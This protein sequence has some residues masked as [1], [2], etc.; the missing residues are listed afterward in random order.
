[1]KWYL[2]SLL[3][4]LGVTVTVNAS[5]EDGKNPS[6]FTVTVAPAPHLVED[7]VGTWDYIDKD[8]NVVDGADAAN[9]VFNADG[10]G[11]LTANADGK[12]FVINFT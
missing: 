3:M 6:V 5:Y 2:F 7:V 11:V 10:T 1:M 4:F 8:G 9:I 12:V